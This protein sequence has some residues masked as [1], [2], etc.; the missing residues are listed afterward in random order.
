MRA[1]GGGNSSREHYVWV[2]SLLW[3]VRI[4]CSPL[5][6]SGRERSTLSRKTAL[7]PSWILDVHKP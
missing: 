2:L 3:M 7:H 6:T 4:F 1:G 5:T